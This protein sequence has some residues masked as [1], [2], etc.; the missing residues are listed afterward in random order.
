MLYL[1]SLAI[2]TGIY[3]VDGDGPGGYDP[4]YTYCDMSDG[5]WTLLMR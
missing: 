2:V 5:G 3:L 4:Q 1:A